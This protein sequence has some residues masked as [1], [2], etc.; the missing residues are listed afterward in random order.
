MSN[1]QK[2]IFIVVFGGLFILM[3]ASSY[4]NGVWSPLVAVLAALTPVVIWLRASQK[5]IAA[6][7]E[8]SERQPTPQETIVCFGGIKMFV[9]VIL[10]ATVL[11]IGTL[12]VAYALFGT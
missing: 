10:A 3:A 6:W 1:S 8:T 5:R 11:G 9:V 7:Q 12:V 4:A 2:I